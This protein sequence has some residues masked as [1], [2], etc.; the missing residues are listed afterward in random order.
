MASAKDPRAAESISTAI[1]ELRPHIPARSEGH[2][3][4]EE[5]LAY[6]L[7]H[8]AK[9]LMDPQMLPALKR[10]VSKGHK[11]FAS[12]VSGLGD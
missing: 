9:T 10:A 4:E 5:N 3:E 1:D 12:V 2:D 11:E 7:A 8:A 6:S